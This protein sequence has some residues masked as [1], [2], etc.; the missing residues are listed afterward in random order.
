MDGKEGRNRV[1]YEVPGPRQRFDM[2]RGV[3]SHDMKEATRRRPLETVEEEVPSV[4]H[5]RV[6]ESD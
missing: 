1:A 3:Q 6:K 2:S 4:A 5:E